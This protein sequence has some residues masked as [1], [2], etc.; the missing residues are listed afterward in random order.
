MYIYPADIML[1]DFSRVDGTKWATVACDQYT[2]EPEYWLGVKERVGDAP[3][4]YKLILPEVWL[5]ESAARI[6]TVHAA[7]DSYIASDWLVEHKACGI[8]LERR[9]SG[10][11][12]RRGIVA[13][14][15]LE[16]YDYSV[17]STSA[18]RATEKTVVERIPPRLEVRRDAALELPHILLLVDDIEDKILG[19]FAG[20]AADAYDFELDG[21]AGA[22]R[23]AF[24]TEAEFAA[25]N[26]A[27]DE[28]VKSRGSKNAPIVFAVGDGNHSLATAKAAY[29]EIKAK[30][31]AEA[32]ASHP[33]RYALCELGNLHD[34][35]LEFEPIYRIVE[36]ADPCDLVEK[37][38]TLADNTCGDAAAQSFTVITEGKSEVITFSKPALT[39]AVGTLQKFLDEYTAEHPD[40]VT[41]YIHGEDTLCRLAEKKGCVGFLFNG[42]E[43][44]ELF[45]AV[46]NDGA[47]PRKTFSMGHAAD[48]RYYVECR[49]IK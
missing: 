24:I 40:T 25:I 44:S 23:G 42:I 33:A 32:A 28:A 26:A 8:Y 19:P 47:L 14:V 17:G 37:F 3:S 9:L 49:K 34:A 30:I 11:K 1:P 31:G 35:S 29:E 18:I 4:A 6:P 27:I 12:I 10:G 41:D 2:S 20:R 36:T 38:R 46:E 22:V 39:L 5:D 15:D 48:K 13:A 45:P 43:K 21:T 7:M 16:D